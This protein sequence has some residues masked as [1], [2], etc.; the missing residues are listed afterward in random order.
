MNQAAAR[1]AAVGMLA[2]V[3]GAALVTAHPLRNKPS[4][5]REDDDRED[6]VF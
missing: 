1:V 6:G 2:L 5:L 4:G 3:L